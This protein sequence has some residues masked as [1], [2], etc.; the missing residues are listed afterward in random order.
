MKFVTLA[1]AAAATMAAAPAFAQ[2]A[3][4]DATGV[5]VQLDGGLATVGDVD[6]LYR[7][8]GDELAASI[9]LDNA[10]TFG[11]ALGYDFGMV[12]SELQIN[13]ARN[14]LKSLK[15]Q[16]L[17]GAPV[18]LSPSD[19]ADFCDYLEADD[20]SGSGNTVSVPGSRLRQLNA[21]AN[22]WLD[23]PTG[24]MVTP[25][26]GGGI[27]VSGFEVD[28]EGKAKFA[29]QIG[30]GVAVAVSEKVSLVADVRHRQVSGGDI[31]DG[32]ARVGKIKTTSFSAGLR[33]RF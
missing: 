18:T 10:F 5:Y 19:I 4:D 20:C 22:L 6:I 24:A 2:S 8:G 29:W 26:V 1:A 14:K 13:Y 9:D 12:R 21:M 7:D 16:T 25:Y 33:F 27:G 11:G 15:V 28:G 23:I 17:N 30:G 32:Y 31:D 3:G